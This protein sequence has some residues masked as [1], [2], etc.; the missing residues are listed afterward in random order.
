[1]VK[2]SIFAAMT[3]AVLAL[4]A[5][6]Q[7]V[8]LLAPTGSSITL[9]SGATT[10]PVGGSTQLIAQVLEASGTPPHSGTHVTFT[11]TLGTVS[12]SETTTDVSGRAIVTFQAGNTSGEATISA[13]SGGATVAKD[14]AIK[15]KIGGAAVDSVQ[16]SVSPATVPDTGGNVTL[17]AL[18]LD[19]SGNLLSGVPVTFSATAGQLSQAVVNTG[20]DGRASTTLTTSKETT[21]SASAGSKKSTDVKIAITTAP[22]ISFGTITPA[23]PTVGD[24]VTF[25]ITVPAPTATAAPIR[26]IT[27]DFGDGTGALAAGTTTTTVSHTYNRADTFTARATA[28]DVN[29][30]STTAVTQVRIGPRAPLAPTISASPANPTPGTPV[31][32]T[33]GT[34]TIPAGCGIAS[35]IVNW[36]DG[37]ATTFTGS[38][39]SAQHTFNA[40]GNYTVQVTETD[41]C[42]GSGTASTIVAVTPRTPLNVTISASANPAPNSPVTFAITATPSSGCAIDRVH[43]N[44]GDGTS[45]SFSGATTSVQHIY[46]ASG[47]YTAT[48]TVTDT[49]GASGIASTSFLVA[50]AAPTASFTFSPDPGKAG[51]PVAFNAIASTGDIVNYSWNYGDG[52]VDTGPSATQTHT[53]VNAGTYTVRLTVTDSLG[54]TATTQKSVPV[55]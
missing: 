50:S 16:L 21:V 44:F 2:K 22:V 15:I 31:T 40:P 19:A 46:T 8:P 7:R 4:A 10:L 18:A 25:T 49:C 29:G 20:S 51:Q 54:R 17:T 24:P 33:I 34:G 5:A 32:F 26:A 30:L 53:F 45:Q 42:G 23:S 38:T 41:T 37:Q 14:A 13:L 55:Q 43:V 28:T 3:M 35:M 9:I 11:T 36:G 48:V 6:C 52:S 39:T 12:P 47:T 1:M 27:V